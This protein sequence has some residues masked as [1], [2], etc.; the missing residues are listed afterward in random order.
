MCKDTT[1]A[2]VCKDAPIK[3][4]VSAAYRPSH[5]VDCANEQPEIHNKVPLCL[6]FT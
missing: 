3:T 2:L 1:S 5:P 4:N 6:E